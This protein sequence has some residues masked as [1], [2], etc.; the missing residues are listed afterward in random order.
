M[1]PSSGRAS[2]GPDA[3][4][5][6]AWTRAGC[7]QISRTSAG[8][9]GLKLT[10]LAVG[11]G[12][13]AH[14]RR[15]P[16][17]PS[18]RRSCVAQAAAAGEA[19]NDLGRRAALVAA[20]LAAGLAADA[21]LRA[22]SDRYSSSG[23]LWPPRLFKDTR[24][25]ELLPGRIWGFEQVISFFTVSANIRMTV[26]RLRDGRLWVSSPVAATGECLRLLSELG[27]VAH[28]VVPG[29]ALEHK[30]SLADFSRAFP[31]ATV[32]V[33]PGQKSPPLDPPLGRIDGILGKG[34]PPWQDEVDY[35]VFFVE[36]PE[37]TGTYAET[38]FFHRETQ[39]LL[40]SDAVLKVPREAPAILSSYGFEGDP[41]ELTPE[42]WYYKF[43]A[44]NFLTM[45]GSDEAD[46]LA[47]AEPKAL[48]SPIL[49][50]TLYPVCQ[51]QA[52]AW[53]RRVAEWP[54]ERVVAA[55]LESP[56]PLTPPEF[57]QAFGFLFGQES[58][59]EPQAQQLSS[60][61]TLAEQ[62]DGPAAL[63]SDIWRKFGAP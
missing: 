53:V 36:P 24:R 54:F 5:P 33:S 60:L 7:P 38:A 21:G 25:T 2:W 42:Q 44:F 61:R 1:L 26:V 17:R 4:G 20:S 49:R 8:K 9:H 57:L 23:T 30:V 46:F 47:L 45:R 55:H 40:V 50:F 16:A 59:W 34:T 43:I 51:Q 48:V 29:T 41:A 28:L 35:R 10:A 56:Y 63:Q 39:T 31:K 52:A 11:V 3:L 22:S 15:F 37:T 27:E 18:P 62:L 6:P 12:R 13:R 19:D 32:W 58:S 14:R